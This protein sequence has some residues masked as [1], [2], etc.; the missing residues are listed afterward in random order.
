MTDCVSSKDSCAR[1]DQLGGALRVDWTL[2]LAQKAPQWEEEQMA[3]IMC[4]QA[5]LQR[6]LFI[7]NLPSSLLSLNTSVHVVIAGSGGASA[8]FPNSS[9][10]SKQ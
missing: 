5:S 9:S 10:Q 7:S 8:V 2:A 4:H 6:W 1:W 3:P